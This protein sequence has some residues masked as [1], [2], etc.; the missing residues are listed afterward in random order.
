MSQCSNTCGSII[1]EKVEKAVKAIE[2][3]LGNVE[4]LIVLSDVLMHCSQIQEVERV[5]I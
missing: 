5:I 4:V 1:Q 3:N 2:D